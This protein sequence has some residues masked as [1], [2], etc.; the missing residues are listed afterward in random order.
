MQPRARAPRARR[1]S[2]SQACSPISSGMGCAVAML[3]VFVGGLCAGAEAIAQTDP[4]L[5]PLDPGR[6]DVGPLS[7]S[8]R[9]RPVDLREPSRFDAVYRTAGDQL[10]RIDGGLTAVFPRSVY[11][12]SPGG[13]IALIPPG[14]I[15]HIG[16][17]PAARAWLSGA[18]AQAA[19]GAGSN[20]TWRDPWVNT[21]AVPRRVQTRI[22]SST[23]QW[24]RIEDP[25]R[26]ESAID[27]HTIWW[28]DAFR[29]RRVESLLARAASQ[30]TRLN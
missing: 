19:P 18:D 14:T 17:V 26:I 7:Q 21:A 30:S 5:R 25:S 8:L 22:E 23:L 10:M 4:P 24:A 13:A 27:V 29:A 2:F 11:R 3:V 12:A 15:F 20:G 9:I 6:G 28:D 16:P 1:D